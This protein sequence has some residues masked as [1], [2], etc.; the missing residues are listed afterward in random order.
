MRMNAGC[1]NEVSAAVVTEVLHLKGLGI[2]P[3]DCPTSIL[4]A[5]S[6]KDWI[7]T[8]FVVLD[9][10]LIQNTWTPLLVKKTFDVASILI[11][12]YMFKVFAKKVI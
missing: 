9:A 7:W 5:L 2:L 10:V 6:P 11:N 1:G 12:C 4:L 8:I 3:I